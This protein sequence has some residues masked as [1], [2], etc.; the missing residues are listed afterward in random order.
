[1]IDASRGRYMSFSGQNMPIVKGTVELWVKPHKDS[2][3]ATAPEYYFY[4]GGATGDPAISIYRDDGKIFAFFSLGWTDGTR[5]SRGWGSCNSAESARKGGRGQAVAAK[6]DEIWVNV[7]G[8]KADE[9][10]HIVVT[11]GKFAFG[12]VLASEGRLY[13]DGVPSAEVMPFATTASGRTVFPMSY[14]DV[15]FVPTVRIQQ[16]LVVQ[17]TKLDK[18]GNTVMDSNGNP[19]SENVNSTYGPTENPPLSVGNPY[20]VQGRSGTIVTASPPTVIPAQAQNVAAWQNKN[21]YIGAKPSMGGASSFAEATI[22]NV[23]VHHYIDNDTYSRSG[24]NFKY[25][26]YSRPNDTNYP[27]YGTRYRKRLYPLEKQNVT[28]GNVGWT[29][30]PSTNA[31]LA[32]VTLEVGSTKVGFY[33]SLTPDQKKGGG[34]SLKQA[35]VVPPLPGSSTKTGNVYYYVDFEVNGVGNAAPIPMNTTP[36]FDDVTFTYFTTA[37]VVAY[38]SME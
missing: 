27:S 29:V 33:N 4:W 6:G 7:P 18:D 3:A 17:V 11:Y 16:S 10:H 34:Y 15:Q 13:V 30:Y 24:S 37:E 31:S 20:T 9:W 26:R 22:D 12:N 25:S 8:W 21:F 19:V 32:T 23:L 2:S 1:M 14:D 36:I 28:L 5:A 38:Y 35:P